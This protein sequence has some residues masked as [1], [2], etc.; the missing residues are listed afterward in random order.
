[1]ASQE[2]QNPATAVLRTVW[3][4]VPKEER[5]LRNLLGLPLAERTHLVTLAYETRCA[6]G[7][8]AHHESWLDN[9]Q[10]QLLT[11]L[12]RSEWCRGRSS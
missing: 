11:L 7:M 3:D 2:E 5:N 9:F 12:E 6:D 1:M 8:N 4:Q 10:A